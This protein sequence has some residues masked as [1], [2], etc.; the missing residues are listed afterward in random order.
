MGTQDGMTTETT[1]KATTA[2]AV[3]AVAVALYIVAMIVA[4]DS[5]EWLWPL[6]GVVGLVGAVMGWNAGKPRPQGKNLAAVVLGGLVFL[7][8]LGWIVWAAATGNM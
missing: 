6:S 5:N 2:L 4:Q 1:S 8:V 3:S 7:T